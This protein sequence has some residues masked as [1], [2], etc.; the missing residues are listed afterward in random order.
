MLQTVRFQDQ[1]AVKLRGLDVIRLHTMGSEIEDRGLLRLWQWE[2]WQESLRLQDIKIVILWNQIDLL[3]FQ[4]FPAS[5]YAAKFVDAIL[6]P[7]DAKNQ[8]IEK[9]PD[10]W[11]D[12]RQEKKGATKDE[13]VE[14]YHWLKGREFEQTPGDG[15][16]Q[17]SLA[18]CI[19]GVIKSQTLAT[20]QQQQQWAEKRV[21][22]FELFPDWSLTH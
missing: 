18:C 9:D 10:A 4:P 11:K 1:K 7:P 5:D 16:G 20:E 2:D 19:R 8:L 3:A 17:G 22:G 12:W 13:M 14:W 6:W 21:F 15:E